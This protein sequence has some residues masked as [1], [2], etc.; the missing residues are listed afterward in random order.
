MQFGMYLYRNGIV[1]AEQFVEAIA[2][3]DE[4]R[5]PLGVLAME[6]GK[7]AVRDVLSILRVQSDLPNDRFGDIAIDLGL[8][9]KQD[10]A[11]LLTLQSD[12]RMPMG[13]CM[14][15]LGYMTEE[16]AAEELSSYRRERERGGASKSQ[17][18]RPSTVIPAP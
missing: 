1:S 6:S 2:L 3:Q 7:L 17:G 4:C 18:C 11:E 16:Q 12:R 14:V 8:L 5:I 10:V 9:T 13:L 15:E